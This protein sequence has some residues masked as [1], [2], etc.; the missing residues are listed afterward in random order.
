MA[1]VSTV[2]AMDHGVYVSKDIPACRV[3]D[4]NVTG[5]NVKT[6]GFVISGGAS[7]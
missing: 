6:M 3:T 1:G 5:L 7:V 2:L 4:R